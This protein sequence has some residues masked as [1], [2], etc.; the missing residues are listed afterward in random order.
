MRSKHGV[1]PG[2]A[3]IM[4]GERRDSSKYVSMKKVRA[5]G[6]R[7]GE[8]QCAYLLELVDSAVSIRALRYFAV[9]V[10]SCRGAT[11]AAAGSN[12]VVDALRRSINR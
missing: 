11:C 6:T 10:V 9:R 1:V 5:A 12:G 4:V 3:V 7:S 2:L 8:T